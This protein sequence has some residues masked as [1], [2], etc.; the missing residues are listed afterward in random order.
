M[1]NRRVREAKRQA[2]AKR[3]QF[4]DSSTVRGVDAQT[5]GEELE[6]IHAKRGVLQAQDVVQESRP[7]DAPLHPV[8]EWRDQVAAEN[9]RVWQA[10]NL[11]KSVEVVVQDAGQDSRTPVYVH[12]PQPQQ[13]GSK[14]GYQPVDMV[15]NRPDLYAI[16]VAECARKLAEAE[17]SLEKLKAAAE[18]ADANSNTDRMARIAVAMQAAQALRAAVHSLN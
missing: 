15:V 9:Y 7:D 8:F 4:R 11:I 18:R 10:R 14:S 3:Y 2:E 5:A 1:S 16:A 17:A 13:D 6:R 12:C